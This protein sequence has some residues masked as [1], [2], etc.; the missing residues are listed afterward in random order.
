VPL[1]AA[2]T[3]LYVLVRFV[4]AYGLWHY[5]EWAKWVSALSGEIYIPFELL[6][7]REHVTVAGPGRVDTKSSGSR[8]HALLRVPGEESGEIAACVEPPPYVPRSLHFPNDK[9]LYT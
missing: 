7:L 3:G 9:Q 8:L 6:E 4:E 5:K 2:G 1:I